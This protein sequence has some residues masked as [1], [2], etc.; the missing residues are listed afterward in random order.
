MIV[1]LIKFSAVGAVGTLAHYA[2]LVSL[3]QLL[4]VNVLVASSI[5]AIAGALVNYSLNYKWTFNSNRRHSEAMVKFFT[6]ATVGFVMNGL[7]M[8]LFTKVLVFH[9]LIAQ[10]M[11]T[12]IVLF[13]N[14]LANHYWTFGE[15]NVKS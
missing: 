13:W 12:G 14:F 2:V 1:K 8:G 9:Y 15:L 4:S 6:V 5:G 11:T 7:F 3:V 10:V